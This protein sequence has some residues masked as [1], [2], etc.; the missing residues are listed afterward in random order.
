LRAFPRFAEFR[1]RSFARVC[2]FDAFLRLAI[3]A[4]NLVGA[5]RNA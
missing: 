1:L 4:P 2:A 3:N 5:R